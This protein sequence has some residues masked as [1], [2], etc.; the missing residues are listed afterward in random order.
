ME[1][2]NLLFEIGKESS[3][4]VSYNKW[5]DIIVYNVCKCFKL[6]LTELIL[7]QYQFIRW[8]NFDFLKPLFYFIDVIF[9]RRSMEEFWN[10]RIYSGVYSLVF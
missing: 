8:L 10:W 2:W 5:V 6:V 4:F 7:T 9:C 1:H 3:S